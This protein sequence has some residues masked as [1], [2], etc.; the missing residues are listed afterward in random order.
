MKLELLHRAYDSNLIVHYVAYKGADAPACIRW[1]SEE[2]RSALTDETIDVG[3]NVLMMPMPLS[4]DTP[5]TCLQCIELGT[6]E[7]VSDDAEA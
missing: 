5:V 2:F 7:A 3:N 1:D 6:R 4:R